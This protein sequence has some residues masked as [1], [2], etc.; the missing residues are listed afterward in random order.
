MSSPVAFILG[1]GPN[2]GAAVAK[3]FKEEGFRVAVAARSLDRKAVEDLGYHG[4]QL[5]LSDVV[6]IGKAFDEVEATYGPAS[7]V[8]YNGK[9]IMHLRTCHF[10]PKR[11][12]LCLAA[13]MVFAPG[14]F[15]D[16]FSLSFG[17]F[18]RNATVSGLNAYEAARLA[19]IGFDKIG[20]GQLRAFIA[21]GNL[22]PWINVPPMMGLS[23]GK[24]IL[25]NIIEAG[26]TAYGP[27]G[28]RFYFAGEVNE[29]GGPQNPPNGEPH[30]EVF[31]NLYKQETQ[32]PWDVR[33]V[34]PGKL[35]KADA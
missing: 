7:A 12:R 20:E 16:P 4:I 8:I 18:S 34:K 24:R 9:S 29:E 19:N 10:Q 26:A 21:T 25:A 11:Y 17:D 33:F 23:A 35:W 5:D 1:Y 28:K 22:L 13:D 31:Y 2:I 30:A 3:K 32:G 14:G 6:A 27:A 15:T